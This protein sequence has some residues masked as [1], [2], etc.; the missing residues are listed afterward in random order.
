MVGY[1]QWLGN[2]SGWVLTVVDTDSGWGLA[3]VDTDQCLLQH[4]D[5]PPLLLQLQPLRQD[6]TC[7]LIGR[8]LGVLQL[9]QLI[10][11]RDQGRGDLV[12]LRCLA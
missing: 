8:G 3:V 1:Q 6:G 11:G 2:N 7:H 4:G 9:C 10:H 12:I 5:G